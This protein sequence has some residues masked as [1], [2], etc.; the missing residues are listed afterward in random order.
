MREPEGSRPSEVQPLPELQPRPRADETCRALESLRGAIERRI[1][2]ALGHRAAGRT[3]DAI[4]VFESVLVLD[5]QNV[6]ASAALRELRAEVIP[7]KRPTT[8]S[9]LF[10]RLF[11][12]R[13]ENGAMRAVGG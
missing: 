13:G 11:R 8:F 2:E 12:R 7:P 1:T 4:R 9:R 3:R 6:I 10:G 5:R